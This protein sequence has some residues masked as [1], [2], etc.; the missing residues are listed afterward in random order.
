MGMKQTN[1]DTS[2]HK[3]HRGR[4]IVGDSGKSGAAPDLAMGEAKTEPKPAV[5]MSRESRGIITS[6]NDNS[7][8]VPA[9]AVREPEVEPAPAVP[10]LSLRIVINRGS[11]GD[12]RLKAAVVEP[13]KTKAAVT[14]GSSGDLI[15][16]LAATPGAGSTLAKVADSLASF[17]TGEVAYGIELPDMPLPDLHICNTD[18][19]TSPYDSGQIGAIKKF[20]EHLRAEQ[21][22]IDWEKIKK[23]PTWYVYKQFT[24]SADVEIQKNTS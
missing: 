2:G 9:S 5:T 13:T 15:P 6:V 24:P 12:G 20:A 22:G 8:G 14:G 4:R 16:S 18:V 1:G 3:R 11:G 7:V 17:P 23:T 10:E 21:F 19:V